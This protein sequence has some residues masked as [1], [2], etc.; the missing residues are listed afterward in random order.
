MIEWGAIGLFVW[1][2]IATALLFDFYNGVNDAANSIAT[3]VATRALPPV[4][5]VLMAAF[6]NF[7]GAFLGTAVATT[8]GSGIVFPDVIDTALIL[9]TVIGGTVWTAI[10]SK[11]GIPISVSHALLGGLVG[12]GLAKAGITAVQWPTTTEIGA[13]FR[14]MFLGAALGIIAVMLMMLAFRSRKVGIGL[15][16]GTVFGSATSLVYTI[17]AGTLEIGKVWG[18][19]LFIFYAPLV[20]FVLSFLFVILLTWIVRKVRPSSTNKWFR[21]LQLVS[22]SAFS[23]GHGT[24]DAQKTMGILAALLFANGVIATFAI[25]WEIIVAAATMI[26]LGTLI[27]GYRVVRTMGHRLTHLD[28]YQGFAAETAGALNLFFLAD[29]GVPAS[30]T[31]TIA[32][33]IIGVGATKSVYAVSWGLARNIMVAWIVTIP[34]AAVIAGL[35]YWGVAFALGT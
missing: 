9:G 31:H 22:A 8:V 3:V 19:V 28:P 4:A 21:R 16:A 30:T 23:L 1:F 13:S 14:V 2:A 34:V 24:N 26:A 6:F 32:G 17:L 25:E 7:A 33:G 29:N 10:A 20:S 27:G 35:A 11:Y 18:T 5:A 15:L 12:A